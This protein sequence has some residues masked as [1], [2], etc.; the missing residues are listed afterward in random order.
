MTSEGAFPAST[1]GYRSVQVG[2]RQLDIT[3]TL[4]ATDVAAF[5]DGSGLPALADGE[6]TMAHSSP[7]W[8][9]NPTEPLA[10]SRVERDGMA[11]AVEV[12]GDGDPR[13][14]RASITATGG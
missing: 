10:G 8:E 5:V 11:I 4:P 14:V 3:F 6:R 1:A 2:P 13:T 12:I 7:L 9:L